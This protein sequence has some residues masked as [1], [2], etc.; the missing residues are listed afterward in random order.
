MFLPESLRLMCYVD[1]PLAALRGSE[2]DRKLN[3]AIMALVWSALGFKLAFAK[4]Q[5]NKTVS[6]IGG[7]LTM[8]PNGVMAALKDSLV[9]DI[10][11]DLGKFAKLNVISVKEL[12]SILGKLN[13]AAGLLILMRPFMEPLY[14]ALRDHLSGKQSNAPPNTVWT[15]QFAPS[16]LWFRAFFRNQGSHLERVFTTSAYLRQGTEVEIGTDAPPWGMGGWLS[17]DGAITHYFADMVTQADADK[18][19]FKIGDSN[20]QQI[21]E[22]LAILVAID[23]WSRHWLRERVVLK[24]RGDNV[25]A[26]IMVIKMRPP[27]PAHAIIARELALRM[28]AMS[29]PPDAIH[30]PGVSHVIAD[31]LSRVYMPGAAGKADASVHHALAKAVRAT[32]P[33]RDDRWYMVQ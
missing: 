17:I 26:L 23:A 13:H 28:A 25:G 18:Y 7:T 11:I 32:V 31:K 9:S 29:F 12:Q 24:L 8:E 2:E 6:W 27:D 3:A 16:L 4:G 22:C 19:G 15:R 10:I 1:D 20:G 33:V 5:L 14:A 21:W 30:T